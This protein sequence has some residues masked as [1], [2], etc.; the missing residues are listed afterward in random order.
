MRD[1]GMRVLMTT[2]RAMRRTSTTL[3]RLVAAGLLDVAI[4]GGCWAVVP[5]AALLGRLLEQGAPAGAMRPSPRPDARW[6]DTAAKLYRAGDWK[7]LASYARRWLDTEPGSADAGNMLGLAQLKLE[8]VAAAR[9]TLSSVAA[10]H[11]RDATAQ[12]Y[13]GWSFLA[14]RDA[15][16][17]ERYARQA[18]ELAANNPE[19]WTV[20]ANAQLLRGRYADAEA[21]IAA[22]IRVAP[23]FAALWV[24]RAYV[25]QAQQQ[26]AN[27]LEAIEEAARLE[28]LDADSRANHA[29]LLARNGKLQAARDVLASLA[30]QTPAGA[31]WN[32][33]GV[34]EFKAGRVSEA[35]ASYRRATESDPGLVISWLNLA[36]LLQQTGRLAESEPALRRVLAVQPGNAS[37]LC[38]LAQVLTLL[39]RRG[40]AATVVVQAAQAEPTLVY[41][42]RALG[43][44]YFN[45]GNWR[46]AAE[47]YE[48]AT[49][50]DGKSAPD[51][52]YLGNARYQQRLRGEAFQA[53]AQAERLDRD[54]LGLLNALARYHGE[55][56]DFARALEYAERGTQRQPNDTLLW[57][58]KGYSLLRLGRHQEAIAALTMATKLQ[59]EQP[60][61][62]TNLGQ[63]Y[64]AARDFTNAIR[65]LRKALDLAPMA[66][67]VR[68]LLARALAG[69]GD[70]RASLA[71]VESLLERA[72]NHVPAWYMFGLLA[73]VTD[74]AADL[75]MAYEELNDLAPPAADALRRQASVRA[76]GGTVDLL[77]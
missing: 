29:L 4:A 74:N 6:S 22:G 42:V 1:D 17:A 60:S 38:S 52:V 32:Q 75:K 53:Y 2:M 71:Q 39:G 11:P 43:A 66:G 15:E 19:A 50:L 59:P 30:G 51:W 34:E 16:Q 28:P 49:K 46:A 67:D 40:E 76:R 70:L 25:L 23:A 24:T 13:L 36:A 5:D 61:P 20:L 55:A 37:A 33:V 44:A 57:N 73:I 8:D 45:L 56:G 7:G 68:L 77:Q 54:D 12:V 65:A 35:E 14:E 72:P 27:A 62:W 9:A 41:D 64:L 48:Q 3:L 58:A 63:A 47:R 69:N 31:A 21:S 10:R 18:I 26:Y